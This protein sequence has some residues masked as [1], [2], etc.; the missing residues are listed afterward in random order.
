[1]G[2]KPYIVTQV[3]QLRPRLPIN[4]KVLGTANMEKDQLARFLW[5]TQNGK[6]FECLRLWNDDHLGNIAACGLD[7]SSEEKTP[8]RIFEDEL[9]LNLKWSGRA[10]LISLAVLAIVAA[11]TDMVWNE[12]EKSK[13]S[14]AKPKK[15]R[16]TL[17]KVYGPDDEPGPE[18]LLGTLDARK[19]KAGD[20]MKLD[21][22]EYIVIDTSWGVDD[23]RFVEPID[24]ITVKKKADQ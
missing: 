2:K 24:V 14:L 20:S 22:R 4:L 5:T 6:I 7:A 19:S 12:L 1:M 21:A 18:I 17:L 16:N 8:L 23:P 3:E 13:E 11:L 15:I 10:L 9:F